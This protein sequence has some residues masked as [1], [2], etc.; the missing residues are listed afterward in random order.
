MRS[1]REIIYDRFIKPFEKRE[2]GNIG[3]ELEFPLINKNGGNVDTV[4]VSSIMDYF[5]KKGFTCVLWGVGGEKLFMENENGDTLSFDNSYNNFE[6]S[7]MYGDNLIEIEKRFSEYY[8]EVQAFLEKENHTLCARGTNPNF[9][10]IDVNHTPFSTYN[11]VQE[12]LYKFP[13]THGYNDFPAFMSSVQTHLD[14]DIKSLPEMYTLFC[15]MDFVRGLLFGNSPDFEGKGWRIFRDY[16]WSKSG[17]GNCPEI[18]GSIDRSFETTDDIVEFFIKKGM[19][20]R[21]RDGKYEVFEPTPIEKYFENEKYGAMEDDIECYLSFRNVEITSRGTLEIRSDC[22]QKEGRF[23]MP[24]AFNLGILNNAEKARES[25]ETFFKGNGI[26]KPSS[27]LRKLVCEAREAEIAP[28]EAL[29]KLCG[30]ML[31]IAREG[32]VKRGK[33][34]E[35]LIK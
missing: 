27:E 10:E 2:R 34:E 3:V 15:R 30:D 1:S 33:G 23:F 4:F 17:F 19:F 32:L 8:S 28:K 11:M 20:N 12:Y 7:M 18:T 29:D 35:K 9:P 6:F 31:E 21:I 14:T 16:L 22:T 25:L 5:E 13:G 24:P 26:D